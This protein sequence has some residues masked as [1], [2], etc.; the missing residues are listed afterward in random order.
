V[1]VVPFTRTF[2]IEEQD[3]YVAETI[4]EN[5]LSGVASWAVD[6][7][8]RL[9]TQGGYTTVASSDAAK[10]TW[11]LDTDVVMSFIDECCTTPTDGRSVAIDLETAID[12]LYQHFKAWSRF[13]GHQRPLTK[14]NF[15]RRLAALGFRARQTNGL[16]LYPVVVHNPPPT[17]EY[18]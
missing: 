8:R 6:G 11:R 1:L 14:V 15:S 12:D 17:T 7:A 2:R 4:I 9:V 16:R 13:S 18:H 3:K 10:R 5:E